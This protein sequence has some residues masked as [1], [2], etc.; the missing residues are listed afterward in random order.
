V[1]SFGLRLVEGEIGVSGR[2]GV[3]DGRE[4]C[5]L[6]WLLLL[7][8]VFAASKETGKT[9]KRRSAHSGTFTCLYGGAAFEPGSLGVFENWG[10]SA[11]CAGWS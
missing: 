11:F 5:C 7:G 9:S 2:E 10:R 8:C 1:V 6:R 3:V 4:G